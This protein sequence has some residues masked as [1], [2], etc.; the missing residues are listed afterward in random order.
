MP[1]SRIMTSPR[2]RRCAS[3][4]A[5]LAALALS[6]AA[7]AQEDLGLDLTDATMDLRPSLAV[8]G[9]ELTEGNPKRDAWI[10]AYLGTMVSTNAAKSNLFATVLNPEEVAQKL[11][12]KYADALK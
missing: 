6:T 9:V 12:D 3:L 11:G 1:Y 10:L 8:I 2:T 4:C 7:H 5:S